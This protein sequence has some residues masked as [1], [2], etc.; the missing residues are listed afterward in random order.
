MRFFEIRPASTHVQLFGLRASASFL[1]KQSDRLSMGLGHSGDTV[2]P[3]SPLRKWAAFTG[4]GR[5]GTRFASIPRRGPQTRLGTIHRAWCWRYDLHQCFEAVA[6]R[7]FFG[8]CCDPFHSKLLDR[9]GESGHRRLE[10]DWDWEYRLPMVE[11]DPSRKDWARSLRFASWMGG[12]HLDVDEKV[13]RDT[14]DA[15]TLPSGLVLLKTPILQSRH[16]GEDGI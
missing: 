4:N 3:E 8:V 1:I 7:S 16:R 2:Q 10:V 6:R 5:P 9:A 12:L 13:V 14:R 11:C 15:T